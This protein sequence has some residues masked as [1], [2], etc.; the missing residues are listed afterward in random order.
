[1]MPTFLNVRRIVRMVAIPVLVT[2]TTV[3]SVSSPAH[4]AP[5][6]LSYVI[7]PHEDDEWSTWSL[8]HGST[9]NYKVF[10]Y[11]TSGEQ[12]GA[13]NSTSNPSGGPRWYQGPGSPVGQPNYSEIDP[14]Q[15][16][17][18]EATQA[19][20][21]GTW[22]AA[23]SNARRLSTRNFLND[24]A[25]Q[26]GALPAGFP[27]THSLTTC[28]AGNTAA[29]VPPSRTDGGNLVTVGANCVRVYNATNGNGKLLFFDMGDGDLTKEEVLW[30]IQ[31]V[32]ANKTTLGIPNLPHLNAIGA[33]RNGVMGGTCEFY[34][35]GDHLAVH[36]ALW[37]YD[38]D[39]GRQ[40]GRTCA[41]DPDSLPANGGRTNTIPAATQSHNFSMSGATRVGPGERRYG[42]L[43]STYWSDPAQNRTAPEQIFS[44]TQS[45]WGRF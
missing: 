40:Y 20:P 21:G 26:D 29:G 9:S 8:V 45:F 41:A 1:M 27:A 31:K 7:L 24:R 16:Q 22:S 42:W 35:H 10:I 12:T 19:V 25:A 30:A 15:G 37:T 28:F 11:M 6:Q 18:N 33:F 44:Q 38:M 2:A 13:C 32:Q 5:V 17:W 3:V 39:I 36:Q 23:C 4:A 43:T 34:N 14:A